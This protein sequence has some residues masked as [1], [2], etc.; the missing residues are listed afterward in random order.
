MKINTIHTK[1]NRFLQ[2]SEVVAKPPKKLY[3]IG[4]L[5]ED[6]PPTVAI[7]GS[8]KPTAYGKEVAYKLAYELAQRGVVVVSGLALGTDGIAHR[9]AL[10]AGG[11]TIAVLANGLD[12][13]YPRSHQALAEQ[14]VKQGGAIVS[15]YDPHVEAY[16]NQFLER[17]RIVSGL[18]DAVVIVE[19]ASRS[20][21]LN[22]AAHALEQGKEAFAVPGN[23]TSPLSAGCNALIKQGASPV[24]STEDILQVIAPTAGTQPHQYALGDTEEEHTILQLLKKGIRDGE[25]LQQESNLD[26]SLFNQTITM[27]EI[28]GVVRALGANQWT[29]T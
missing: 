25:I 12:Y 29:I 21:T 10:E 23:I 9:G 17:N 2:R 27:L 26:A 16:P 8:R 20:G 19:A 24:T 13:I 4:Q 22:T 11:T 5:P 28:K 1:D 18:S 15:E 14:I 3:F 6:I 7:V